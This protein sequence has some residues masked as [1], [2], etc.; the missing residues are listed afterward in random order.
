MGKDAYLEAKILS[1]DP[2][3]LIAVLYEAAL[4]TVHAAS[5]HLASKDIPA[6]CNAISRT[7]DILGLLN[8]SLDRHTGGEISRNLGSLYQYMQGR[9]LDAN[10]RQEAEPLEEVARLLSTLA[11]GW[12]GVSGAETQDQSVNAHED[13]PPATVACPNTWEALLHQDLSC[14][15]PQQAWSF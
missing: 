3:G 4:D 15:P 6:R 8:A 14:P 9:L 13:L 2:I 5:E 12:R 1:A 11:E 7:L 10:L